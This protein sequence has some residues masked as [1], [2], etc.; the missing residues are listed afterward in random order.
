MNKVKLTEEQTLF[1]K[2]GSRISTYE[3]AGMARTPKPRTD[4]YYMPYWFKDLGDGELEM[5]HVD[6]LPNDLIHEIKMHRENTHG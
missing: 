2:Q 5:L 1:M 6:R 4:Y 3:N